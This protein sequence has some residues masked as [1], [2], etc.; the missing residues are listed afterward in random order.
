M[1]RQRLGSR[2]DGKH[3]FA[4]YLG[5]IALNYGMRAKQVNVVRKM[6]H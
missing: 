4:D 5:V 2:S 6:K 3:R 1:D